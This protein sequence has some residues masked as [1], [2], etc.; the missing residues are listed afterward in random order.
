MIVF[1]KFASAICAVIATAF[2]SQAHA[3][4][5]IKIGAFLSITGGASFLGDPQAKTL[6][7]YVE[8]INSAGGVLGRK[9]EL[10]T[11]D[12]QGDAKQAVTFV[13]RLL[14]DDK[15]DF[16]I[17][18]STTGATMAV[19]P[20]IEQAGVPFFSMAGASVVV[21]PTKK[22]VFKTAG[23]DR[24]AV[25]RI[26]TDMAK[27]GFK[28]IALIAGS[29][30]FDQSCRTEAK[31]L[32]NKHRISIVADE[33]YAPSDTDMTPQFTRINSAKPAAILSCGFGA[34][35]VISVRNYKQLALTMPLYF[36]HGVGS[37]QFVD[38]AGGAADGIRV[39]VS[40]VLVADDLPEDD[41]QRKVVRNYA[42]EYKA[43][44]NEEPAAFGGFAYDALFM[45]LDAIKR[46]GSADKAK[47]RD[48]IEKTKKFVGLDGVFSM[49]ATDHMGLGPDAFKLTE[50]KAGEWKLL[51]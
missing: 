9:L 6:K 3:A 17:G 28:N 14:E 46:A 38:G 5:P 15:V 29:G 4:D 8:K 43:A 32:A 50:I 36:T 27:R 11:Y 35:T 19:V 45:T 44:F 48:E 31:A 18:G 30:G 33:T 41:P 12:S 39:T 21:E 20:M 24:M 1:R 10:I 47:V 51:K 25:D 2:I 42:K 23:T 16:I 37:Q 49:S 13:R 40:A 26:F 34:P 22:W 7:L